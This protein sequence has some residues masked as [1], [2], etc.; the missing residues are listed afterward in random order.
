MF[1]GGALKSL[2]GG[3][4]VVRAETGVCLTVLPRAGRE[5]SFRAKSI[6]N[7]Y[8]ICNTLCVHSTWHYRNGT[9][10]L[11]R[12]CLS[13]CRDPQ[14]RTGAGDDLGCTCTTCTLC[15]LP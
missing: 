9:E 2:S 15:E 3:A 7:R 1:H 10:L 11:R 4:N 13:Y 5:N 14:S 12:L 6:L 8:S